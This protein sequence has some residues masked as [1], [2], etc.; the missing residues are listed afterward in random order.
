MP[1]FYVYTYARIKVSLSHV[2][3]FDC[4]ACYCGSVPWQRTPASSKWRQL[5]MRVYVQS[6][7]RL[8]D[9]RQATSSR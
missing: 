1:G 8:S 7:S 4:V 2:Q 3:G 5:S 6:T 9:P